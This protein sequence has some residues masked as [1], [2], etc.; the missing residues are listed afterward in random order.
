M[1]KEKHILFAC[2]QMK[3]LAQEIANDPQ[4]GKSPKFRTRFLVLD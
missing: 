2:P 4:N 1:H 3:D